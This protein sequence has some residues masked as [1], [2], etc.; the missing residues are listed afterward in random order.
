MQLRGSQVEPQGVNV[1]RG[2]QIVFSRRV[3]ISVLN[4]EECISLT[5]AHEVQKPQAPF[6][7]APISHKELQGRVFAF[8]VG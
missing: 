3:I 2:K 5:G 1:D 8:K 4:L 6:F 7:W